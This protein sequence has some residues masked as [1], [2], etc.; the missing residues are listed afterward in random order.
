ML[1]LILEDYLSYMKTIKGVSLNTTKEYKYDLQMFFRF[2]KLRKR[3]IDTSIVFEEIPIDDIDEEFFQSIKL[4]DVIAFL[5]YLDETRDNTSVTRSRKVAALHS[6][7]KYLNKVIKVIQEDPSGEISS[8]KSHMRQPVYLTL[9]ESFLLLDSI[10]GRNMARDY[11]IITLF[12]NCGMRISELVG[13]DID[14]MRGDLLTV[15]GK[16]NKE[17]TIYLNDACT[18]A[19]NVYLSV[20]PHADTNALFLSERKSRIS[21]RAVQHMLKKQLQNA[22]LDSRK[23]TP[24]KLRHTAATL[25]YKYGNVDIRAL[26]EILGHASVSTTEIYTHIDEDRLR[27][28]VNSNP[29][30]NKKK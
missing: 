7:F 16:G 29:L 15:I 18:D 2:L 3:L 25:M 30:A 14:K 17:R 1:P 22:A 20:R 6:F 28:A 11:A 23:Y 10:D 4:T 5:T 24:H 21:V 27:T 9:D 12:L 26:Q 19:I 13:I 8:P